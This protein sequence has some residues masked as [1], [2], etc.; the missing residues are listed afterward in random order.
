[1]CLKYHGNLPWYFNLGKSRYCNKLPWYFCNA[2]QKYPAILTLEKGGTTINYCRKLTA[3]ACHP[4]K[5]VNKAEE[6]TYQSTN[7]AQKCMHGCASGCSCM[8]SSS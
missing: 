6:L 1:L 5:K 4:T 3:L 2:G 7:T 8:H